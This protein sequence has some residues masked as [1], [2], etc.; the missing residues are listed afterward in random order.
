MVLNRYIKLLQCLG[1]VADNVL[2]RTKPH[3]SMGK[4]WN[5]ATE[6]GERGVCFASCGHPKLRPMLL[7]LTRRC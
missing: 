5:D 7:A 2:G 4:A 6:Y 3:R 1:L